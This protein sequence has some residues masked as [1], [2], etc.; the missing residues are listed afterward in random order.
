V[1]VAETVIINVVP[2]CGAISDIDSTRTPDA[3]EPLKYIFP[4]PN[5]PVSI[6]SENLAINF[7]IGYVVGSYWVDN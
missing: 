5:V 6:G 3:V 4:L 1:L 2:S 7:V